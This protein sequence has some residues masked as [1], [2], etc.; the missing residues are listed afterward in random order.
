M[1]GITISTSPAAL[2]LVT[3]ARAYTERG[4]LLKGLPTVAARKLNEWCGTHVRPQDRATM[5]G[6]A[7]D[8]LVRWTEHG[9]VLLTELPAQLTAETGLGPVVP[10]LAARRLM[11]QATPKETMM[12]LTGHAA[13]DYAREHGLALCK[14]ADPVEDARTGLTVDEAEQI[15]RVD[16]GL[17]YVAEADEAAVEQALFA[18]A[19]FREKEETAMTYYAVVPTSGRYSAGEHVRAVHVAR[20]VDTARRIAARYTRQHRAALAAH[21][22]TSGGYRIVATTAPTRRTAVWRGHDLDRLPSL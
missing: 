1:P 14:Y 15:A 12:T 2:D 11:R 19:L 6:L 9:T 17:I 21:G 4:Y 8:G 10:R 16:A 20:S 22:G 7:R 3:A 13:I 5:D 18:E